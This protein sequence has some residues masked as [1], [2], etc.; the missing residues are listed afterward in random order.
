MC[1]LPRGIERMTL[2]ICAVG[3]LL[4]ACATDNVTERTRLPYIDDKAPPSKVVPL[5]QPILSPMPD[6]QPSEVPQ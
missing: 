1:K 5:P 3:M 4:T 2:L 6:T